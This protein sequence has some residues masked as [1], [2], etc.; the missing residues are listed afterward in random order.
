MTN[1][2]T[3][4]GEPSSLILGDAPDLSDQAASEVLELLYQLVNAFEERYGPQLRNYYYQSCES[5]ETQPDL[6]DDFEDDLPNF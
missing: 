5:K 1:P 6:F 2:W 3:T 4:P